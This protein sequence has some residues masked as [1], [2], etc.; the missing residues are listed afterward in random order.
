MFFCV[1]SWPMKKHVFVFSWPDWLGVRCGKP[2]D[3]LVLV[4]CE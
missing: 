1:F 2:F 4:I 3:L